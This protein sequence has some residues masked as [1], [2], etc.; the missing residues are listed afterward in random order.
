MANTTTL[1]IRINP[2]VKKSAEE[3]LEELGIPMSTAINIYLRQI[4]MTGSIPFP[5]KLSKVPDNLNVGTM[6][7][8]ELYDKLDEGYD[9][10]TAGRVHEASDAFESLR[11]K[12][13][14]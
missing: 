13:S 1:N 14:I 9:D 12:N 7:D 4:S 2:L 3:V 8:T 6:T 10:A 11:K 5:I